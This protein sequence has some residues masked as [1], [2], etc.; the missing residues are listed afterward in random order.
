MPTR[1]IVF[2]FDGVIVDSEPAHARSIE[3]AL[4]LLGLDFPYAN[5]YSRFIGRG[6]KE[7]FIEVAREQGRELTPDDLATL[8]SHK[9]RAFVD[10]LADGFIRP[11]HATLGLIREA[12]KSHPLAVCSGSLRGSVLPALEHFKIAGC[13]RA[14]VTAT[15]AARNKPDPLPYLMAAER[16]G[17]DPGFC[18]AIEDSPTGIRSARAAATV[19]SSVSVTAFPL[20]N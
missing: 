11:Y 17:L 2:D 12:A 15:E 3:V 1:A 6:D 10:A 18:S 7:C 14:I 5:D 19:A 4:N 16:L 13:F 20:T 9:E 8:K